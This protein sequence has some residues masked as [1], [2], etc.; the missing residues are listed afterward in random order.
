MTK[1]KYILVFVCMWLFSWSVCRY[2]GFMVPETDKNTVHIFADLAT[3]PTI[4]EMVQFVKLRKSTRKFVAW[5]IYPDIKQELLG[6]YNAAQIPFE[7]KPYNKLANSI[8]RGIKQTV[9]KL[10]KENPDT[11]F[12]FHT[13]IYHSRSF[14]FPILR[15]IP[16]ENVKHIY[17]YEDGFANTVASRKKD[18]LK[19]VTPKRPKNIN[20]VAYPYYTH[21][22]YPVTYYL[23]YP[24]EIWN[25][26]EFKQLAE[27]LQGADVRAVDFYE[28]KD[29][30]TGSQK[31]TLKQ[32]LNFNDKYFK[33][34]LETGDQKTVIL[35][36]GRPMN[37]EE[38]KAFKT[39]YEKILDNP[40]YRFIYKPHPHPAS[41]AFALRLK[42]KYKDLIIIP[43]TIPMEA[44]LLFDIIPDY[45]AGYSSSVFLTFKTK[46]IMYIERP[47][48]EYLP[49]MLERGIIKQEDIIHLFEN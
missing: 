40:S 25:K 45:I 39:V 47:N 48:D 41:E 42:R 44:F 46:F 21:F 38:R 6:E 32:F 31:K 19:Y 16:K 5:G 28:I 2:S 4:L 43:R 12:V 37:A 14:L 13:N 10:L 26:P 18:T 9:L 17:L 29:S 34:L 23:A 15:K 24:E 36:G 49:F 7:T 27:I 8:H 11:K 22:T 1:L 20:N 3:G 33:K 30:L 35:L